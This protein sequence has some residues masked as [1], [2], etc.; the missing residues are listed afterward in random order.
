MKKLAYSLLI[1]VAAGAL[2]LSAC[3]SSIWSRS[4]TEIAF[5][6]SGYVTQ[7]VTYTYDGRDTETYS[8]DGTYEVVRK[9]WDATSS[10]WKQSAGDKGTY[11]YDTD[12]L[13]L[14]I[15]YTQK[16]SGGIGGSYITLTSGSTDTRTDS[17]NQVLGSTNEYPAY[18]GSG[19]TYAQTRNVTYWDGTSDTAAWTI[20]VSSD[21]S[22]YA[23]TTDYVVYD[24]TGTATSGSSK[25]NYIYTTSAIFPSSVTSLDNAKGQTVT[26]NYLKY[27]S[28]PYTW[29]SGTTFTAGTPTTNNSSGSLTVSV[30]GD[31]SY[32]TFPSITVARQMASK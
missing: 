30:A 10:T 29:S 4:D 22:T 31:G 3:E 15:N 7:D 26:L 28:I 13:M 24:A 8:A 32:L 20:T 16:W 23:Y 25:S 6:S 2:L 11:S 9:A 1:A 27:V 19:G 5:N 21:L 14:T 17:W 12:I 18:L